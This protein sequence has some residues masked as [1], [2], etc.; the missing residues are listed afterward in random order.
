[1]DARR[2]LHPGHDVLRRPRI[3]GQIELHVVSPSVRQPGFAGWSALAR[4]KRLPAL[5]IRHRGRE[6]V[7]KRA[8]KAA[9]SMQ[10]DPLHTVLPAECRAEPPE[11]F[12]IGQA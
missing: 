2:C 1:E 8:S 4:R 11:M 5:A 9:A 3:E 7:V 6:A 10:I 12:Y